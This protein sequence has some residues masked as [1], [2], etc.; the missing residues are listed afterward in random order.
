[1][2]ALLTVTTDVDHDGILDAF[3]TDPTVFGSPRDLN[4]KLHLYFD[5]R[6][7]YIEE[8]GVD[9]INGQSEVTLMAWVKLDTELLNAGV[10]IGQNKFWL[11]INKSKR[12]RR[13]R[14]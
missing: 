2:M 4:Q 13:Y 12:L 3:D 10:I 1:M 6:N 5:G 7:D 9:I 8:L 11:Q 14:K